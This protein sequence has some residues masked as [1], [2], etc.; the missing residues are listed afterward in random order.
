[1]RGRGRGNVSKEK[2]RGKTMRGGKKDLIGPRKVPRK[3][4]SAVGKGKEKFRSLSWKGR[5][6][7]A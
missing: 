3:K 6:A 4:G 1:V 7:S 2:K 5:D